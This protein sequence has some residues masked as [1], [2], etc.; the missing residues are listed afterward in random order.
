M[1]QTL[2]FCRIAGVWQQG[3]NGNEADIA[4]EYDNETVV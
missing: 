1:D 2:L 4:A 3:V